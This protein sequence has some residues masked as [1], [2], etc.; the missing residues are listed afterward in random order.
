M[1]KRIHV[2]YHDAERI[3]TERAFQGYNNTPWS[4][5]I[6]VEPERMYFSVQEEF[7][8]VSNVAALCKDLNE[9]NAFFEEVET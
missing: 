1:V 6:I 8:G 9:L 3:L 4:I 2:E 5:W 7:F